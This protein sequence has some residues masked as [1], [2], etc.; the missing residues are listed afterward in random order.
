MATFI[1]IEPNGGGDPLLAGLFQQG[2][3]NLGDMLN[4]A[5]LVAISIG[6][7][8]AMIRL[9]WGGWLYMGSSGMWTNKQH[10]KEVLQNAIIGLLILFAVWII[11]NQIN[12][13]ILQVGSFEQSVG[14]LQ[15]A[16]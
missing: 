7:I 13:Q 16:Q 12:P 10:A 3:V 4:T 1:P 15:N 2:N 5:F 8:L 14:G 9:I 11:L 6:S